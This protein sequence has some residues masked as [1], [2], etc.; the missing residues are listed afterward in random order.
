MKFLPFWNR[1]GTKMLKRMRR[2]K[3]ERK[4]R[5]KARNL[6]RKPTTNSKELN[7]AAGL[8]EPRLQ[9]MN[10]LKTQPQRTSGTTVPESQ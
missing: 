4:P 8:T 3:P 1:T 10:R 6:M 9:A 7:S 2:K 5:N